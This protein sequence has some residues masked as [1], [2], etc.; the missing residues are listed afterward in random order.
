[1][2]E[3]RDTMLTARTLCIPCGL[4]VLLLF[5][6]LL[7]D[8]QKVVLVPIVDV[9]IQSI[10]DVV[11][12]SHEMLLDGGQMRSRDGYVL[13]TAPSEIDSRAYSAFGLLYVSSYPL[14][15]KGLLG[16]S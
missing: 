15:S 5:V 2:N 9:F 7:R 1:M 14:D 8:N 3:S 13:C 4:A 10:H 6:S 11:Q 12:V 16:V